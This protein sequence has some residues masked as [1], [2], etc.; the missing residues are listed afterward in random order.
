MELLPGVRSAEVDTAR[1]R[2]HFLEAGPPDGVPVVLVHGNLVTGRY[3][4]SLMSALAGEDLRLLAPDM[5]G[6][7]RTDRAPID[8]TRGLR[9]W[10]DDVAAFLSALGVERPVHLAGWSTGGGAV[11]TYALDRPAASL[12][13]IAPV[14]PYGFG[15]CRS[16]GTPC[17]PDWAGTGGGTANP[18]FVRRIAAGDRSADSPFSP[19]NV[20]TTYLWAPT[21]RE[22]P[23]REEVLLDEMLRTWVSDDGY[24]GAATPS[25]SWPGMAPGPRGILNALSGRYCNWSGLPDVEPKPPV[26]WVHGSVDAVIADGS[27][28]ELGTLGQLGAVPGW[29]GADAYPP[30]PMVAQIR[31]VL[32]RYRER[33]G[34]VTVDVVEGSGH[35]P[36]LDAADR[37]RTAF[38]AHVRAAEA[39]RT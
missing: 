17:S 28:F 5:R 7:G 25:S 32:D 15:G 11:A 2:M 37:F 21:H 6:F 8:A 33:G 38:L 20:M 31:A 3:F 30:Q 24:P 4:E 29:P 18:E 19:R 16:D 39:A 10:A 27:L 1:L 34:Q 36:V 9:D 26:L 12:V 13:L 22:P 23:E 35:F 14:S